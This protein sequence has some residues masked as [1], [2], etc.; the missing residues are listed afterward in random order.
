MLLVYPLVRHI[1]RRNCPPPNRMQPPVQ[2]RGRLFGPVH[3]STL[4]YH[5]PVGRKPPQIHRLLPSASPTTAV[6][7]HQSSRLAPCLGSSVSPHLIA[8]HHHGGRPAQAPSAVVS[9]SQYSGAHLCRLKTGRRPNFWRSTSWPAAATACGG[10]LSPAWWLSTS[11]PD[12]AK[13]NSGKASWQTIWSTPR[14]RLLCRICWND[15]N[16]AGS[17]GSKALSF[18]LHSWVRQ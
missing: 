4:A 12:S 14:P 9:R 15:G 13:C 7:I 10:P 6:Q 16:G 18:R 8:G 3:G 11:A 17:G 5:V 1:S 2:A